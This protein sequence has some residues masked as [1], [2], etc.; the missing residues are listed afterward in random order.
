MKVTV[1]TV[2]ALDGNQCKPTRKFWVKIESEDGSALPEYKHDKREGVTI[3]NPNSLSLFGW[4]S[5]CWHSEKQAFNYA[6]KV[7]NGIGC[8]VTNEFQKTI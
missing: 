7:A 8:E 5:A 1:K 3:I 4:F 2:I 6:V